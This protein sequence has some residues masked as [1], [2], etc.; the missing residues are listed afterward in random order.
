MGV[1][2]CGSWCK[3]NGLHYE[4]GQNTAPGNAAN[5]HESLKYV[6]LGAESV[7]IKTFKNRDL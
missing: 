6:S 1:L 7:K 3:E 2:F 5:S 4:K